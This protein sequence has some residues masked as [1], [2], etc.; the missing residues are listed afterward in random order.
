MGE[1]FND[2]KVGDEVLLCSGGWHCRETIAKVEKVTPKQFVVSG[3][4]YRKENGCEVDAYS[5]ARCIHLTDKVRERV[6]RE[7]RL[8]EQRKFISEFTKSI[9]QNNDAEQIEKVYDLLKSISC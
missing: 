2:V 7:I 8:A 9:L 5:H 3:G 4:H 1:N 6:E